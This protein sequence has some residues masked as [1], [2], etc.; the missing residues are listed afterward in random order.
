MG[1]YHPAELKKKNKMGT[2]CLKISWKS[3]KQ[4]IQ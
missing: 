3:F 2:Y 1:D 4:T